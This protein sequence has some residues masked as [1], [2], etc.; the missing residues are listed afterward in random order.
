MK[1]SMSQT[2]D[3]VLFDLDGTLADTAPDLTESLN[4]VFI[5]Q[6]KQPVAPT[7]VRQVIS[8]GSTAMLRL[9]LEFSDNSQEHEQLKQRLFEIYTLR[10]HIATELFDGMEHC[11]NRLEQHGI[12][13]GIVTNK[14]THLTVPLI[15]TLNLSERSACL[16]CADTTDHAKP[17]P[18]PLLHAAKLLDTCAQHCVYVG[19]ARHD[20]SAAK[21]ANMTAVVA[22]YGYIPQ[23][24]DPQRWGADAMIE[25]PTGILS[26]LNLE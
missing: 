24:D 13:W 11:L 22:A 21:R 20:V 8:Q 26:W 5:E 12:A 17:H 15:N 7:D 9:R 1:R 19:D 18:A 16:V 23:T 6:G 25:S 10:N 14:L 3:T 4:Q 2:I